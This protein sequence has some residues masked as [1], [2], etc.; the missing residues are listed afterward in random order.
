MTQSNAS[1]RDDIASL[2]RLLVAERAVRFEAEA[3]ATLAIAQVSGAEASIAHLK[4]AIEKMRSELY[5]SRSGRG[6]KLLE[7]MEF[8]L[9]DIIATAAQDEEAAEMA[10]ICAGLSIQAHQRRRSGQRPF[11]DH[12]PRERIII[13]GRVEDIGGPVG[14]ADFI[15]AIANPKHESHAE[16]LD[17]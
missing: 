11:P 8:E 1:E 16:A 9:E 3:K 12:L 6:H 13:P 10:A 17:C 4:L 5:G 2:K 7:Q 15:K 14:Y